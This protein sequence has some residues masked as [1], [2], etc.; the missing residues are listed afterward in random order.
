MTLKQDSLSDKE[1]PIDKELLEPIQEAITIPVG[2]A[3]VWDLLSTPGSLTKFHP[4]VQVHEAKCWSA[5]LARDGL[6]YY[7]GLELKR[8]SFNWLEGQGFDLIVG[9]SIDNPTSIVNWRISALSDYESS[10]SITINFVKQ[11]EDHELSESGEKLIRDYLESVL[12]GACHYLTTGF[13][14]TKNQ[15]GYLPVFSVE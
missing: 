14:V 1:L 8:K 2:N 10:L 15:F 5:D 13:T 6:T 9:P 11:K 4:F 3:K 12:L 7:S